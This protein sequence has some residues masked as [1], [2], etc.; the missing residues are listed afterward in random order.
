MKGERD[1]DVM[2]V[3]CRITAITEHSKLI[4]KFNLNHH[5]TMLC[6]KTKQDTNDTIGFKLR[7]SK[8]HLS[9]WCAFRVLVENEDFPPL[10]VSAG[11][12]PLKS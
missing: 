8:N 7:S 12:L 11:L 4:A 1:E 6:P 9:S 10:T 2:W 5:E 3:W